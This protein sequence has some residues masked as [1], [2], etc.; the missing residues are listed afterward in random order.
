MP[1]TPKSVSVSLTNVAATAYTVPAA[2]TAVVKTALGQNV[3]GGNS[4]FTIQKLSGGVYS[5]LIINQTPTITPATGG[6]AFNSKNLIDGPITLAA[7]ESL[8]VSD[9]ATAA[10]KFPRTSTAFTSL[11]S[12]NYQMNNMLFGNGV[13]IMVGFD[14]TNSSSIVLR[15]TDGDNWTEIATGNLL[16]LSQ[17]YFISRIGSTWVIGQWNAIN[18]MYS[19]DNGLTWT[20]GA[21]PAGSLIY[22]VASDGAS[23]WVM[24]T[25]LGVYTST[26]LPTWTLNTTLN[27]LINLSYNSSSNP[28]YIPQI[29]SWNG[30]Y[31]FIA[32]AYG[33][34][35]TTN[36][37]TFNTLFQPFGGGSYNS[38]FSGVRWSSVYSRYYAY[39]KSTGN[40]LDVILSSTNGYYWTI[41]T[42]GTN[43][44]TSSNARINTAA[45]NSVLIASGAGGGSTLL[46][47]TDGSTWSSATNTRGTL[48]RGGMVEG[49]ANGFFLSTQA[50]GNGGDFYLT[51]DPTTSSGTL[52]TTGAGTNTSF[53]AAASDGTG[54]V[55]IWYDSTNSTTKCAYGPN[56]TTMTS[57][58]AMVDSSGG[59]LPCQV[60]WWPAAN[61]YVAADIYGYIFTSPTG[62]T[63]TLRNSYNIGAGIAG[64][65]VCGNFLYTIPQGAT[66]SIRRMAAADI[67]TGWTT[68]PLTTNA[69]SDFNS[70]Y[71]PA[72]FISV[73][74]GN[75]TAGPLTT[76][77]TDIL[78]SNYSGST[79]I[80]TPSVG[81]SIRTP[82][83]GGVTVERVNN[84]DIAYTGRLP[85]V[86]TQPTG[87]FYSSD[88]TSA[89]PTAS[90][91]VSS[92]FN[93]YSSSN[94]VSAGNSTIYKKFT[95]FGGTYYITPDDNSISYG[96]NIRLLTNF[97]WSSTSVGR[98][99]TIL[100][101][102]G[103]NAQNRLQSDGTNLITYNSVGS[104]NTAGTWKGTNPLATIAAST[105]TFG[106]VE[107][108]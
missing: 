78:M 38:S 29:A 92:S 63:W 55:M 73:S 43:A 22:C 23:R 64:V 33:T 45:G 31:W 5:P 97:T 12:S 52:F 66:N 77:G 49:L 58:T 59:Y 27:N 10:F 71:Y 1:Q 67:T 50:N 13:Y 91:T 6:T 70:G 103:Q 18:Y 47:S 41:T 68:I 48:Y 72:D 87:F 107:N 61:L 101:A 26:S 3:V 2:T 46:K 44:L 11:N 94:P 40:T 79:Y 74:N 39:A 93:S 104:S 57:A 36:F 86:G 75:N 82:G 105:V 8:I 65:V 20:A 85:G 98:I 34:W 37:T 76:N 17:S 25:A 99:P 83:V 88:L 89:L 81:N 95:F 90:V 60:V 80:Y 7:G 69:Y 62:A 96:T 28:T 24:C 35:V 100:A 32:S 108:T 54:W 19:T 15:S 14:N 42:P 56:S 51:T 30:T 4:S 102:T 84:L 21:L 16:P 53:R 9:S 106:I